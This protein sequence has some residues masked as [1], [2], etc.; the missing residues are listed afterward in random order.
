MHQRAAKRGNFENGGT[1]LDHLVKIN[2][3][4]EKGIGRTKVKT[5][6][7]PMTPKVEPWG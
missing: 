1:K 7:H 4:N 3:A 6:V 2:I 5:S